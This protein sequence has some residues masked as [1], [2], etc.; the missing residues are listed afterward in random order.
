M[1]KLW[2]WMRSLRLPSPGYGVIAFFAVLFLLL[3][4]CIRFDMTGHFN[5]IFLLKGRHDWRFEL[6]DDLYV[7][8]GDRIIYSLSFNAPRYR[9]ARLLHGRTSGTPRLYYEWDVNEGSGFIRNF[10]ADGTQL[11]TSFG[12][13]VDDNNQHVHGLFVGG[14][15]PESV[16]G[17]DNVSMNNTG[18]SH[19]DG[20]RWYHIWCNVNEGFI[21]LDRT[22]ASEPGAW[23]FLGSKV[24]NESGSTLVVSSSH[25][26][27]FEG[28]PLRVDRYVYFTVGDTFFTLT[29]KVT[30]LGSSPA[31]FIYLY[32]DEPWVGDYGTSRGDVGWVS[33]GLVNYETKIDSLK[34][35]YAGMFHY[36]NSAFDEGHNF[37]LKANFIEWFGPT[38]PDV[39]FA[40]LEGPLQD[41]AGLRK[42]PLKSNSR[43]IGLEWPC[44]FLMPQQSISYNLAIGMAGYDPVRKLPVK[45]DVIPPTLY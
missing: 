32:G 24:L 1:L 9:L 8:D 16:T 25:L 12:R 45:P 39:Y 5:G 11:L 34:Y 41:S 17:G 23:K 13:F 26:A 29:I 30:N 18:M 28:V 35:T 21:S 27:Q 40:N 14:G 33:D 22:R 43:F 36:G 19:F 6:K 2:N 38:R 31:G 3:V 20:R 15:M 42:I 10:L 44:R 37:T 4:T 7:G